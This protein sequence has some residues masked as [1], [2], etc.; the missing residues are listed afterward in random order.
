MSNLPAKPSSEESGPEEDVSV[1]DFLYQDERRIASFLAQFDPNGV[2]QSLKRTLQ[3]AQSTQEG[4]KGSLG[5]NAGLIKGQFG[6]D[7]QANRGSSEGSE[8]VYDPMWSNARAFLDYVEQRGL[9]QRH[10]QHARMGQITLAKGD[11][12]ML[13]MSMLQNMLS[14][15]MLK[16]ALKGGIAP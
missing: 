1:F 16:R 14:N 15:S 9:L 12:W 2:V 8:R 4:S 3:A 6:E 7:I 13:D 5:V 10:I 11:L